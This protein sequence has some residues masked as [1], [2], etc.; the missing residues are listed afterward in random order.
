M[1]SELSRPAVTPQR[2]PILAHGP[3]RALCALVF[4]TAVLP[5]SAQWPGAVSVKS[6]GAVGDGQTDDTA[7]F[8]SALDQAAAC[9]GP[10]SYTH[11]TLPTLHSV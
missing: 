11:L 3:A 1:Q 4:L 5:A 10:V 2:H 9:G 7:A 6:C 8:Q